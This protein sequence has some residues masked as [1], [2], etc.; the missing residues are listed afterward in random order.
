MFNNRTNVLKLTQMSLLLAL[1]LILSFTPLGFILIPPV[2]IT[3]LHIPVIIAAILLGPACGAILGGVFG[4]ISIF[5]ATTA[6]T[7]PVDMAFSPFVSGKPLAS[8]LMAL[9]TRIL[10]GLIAGLLFMALRKVIKSQLLSITITAVISTILHTCMVLGCLALFFNDL[11]VGLIS[12]LITIVSLNGILEI[13]VGA[14]VTGA[15]C[16]PLLKMMRHT[17]SHAKPLNPAAPVGR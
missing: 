12:I 4:L 9:G 8:L 17:T 10:F 13:A 16:N 14:I 11:G 1:E 6:A 7:S 15:I 2:A 5:K 3:L